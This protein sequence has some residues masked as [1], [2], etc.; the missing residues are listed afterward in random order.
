MKLVGNGDTHDFINSD[1]ESMRRNKMK[2]F[3]RDILCFQWPNIM[4]KLKS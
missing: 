1:A 4:T 3:Y 2:I